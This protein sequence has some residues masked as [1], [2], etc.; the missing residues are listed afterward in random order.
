MRSSTHW[1]SVQLLAHLSKLGADGGESCLQNWP[2]NGPSVT[3]VFQ[4]ILA[5]L[6]KEATYCSLLG[7]LHTCKYG[8]CQLQSQTAPQPVRGG[9]SAVNEC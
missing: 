7:M 3:T 9:R 1:L 2:T 5:Q 4:K 8:R 6:E